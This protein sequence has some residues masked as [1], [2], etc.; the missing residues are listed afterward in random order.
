MSVAFE[1]SKTKGLGQNALRRVRE[2]FDGV[3]ASLP[4]LRIARGPLEIGEIDCA[5]RLFSVRW[6]TQE[7]RDL[8]WPA[9]ITGTT[10]THIDIVPHRTYTPIGFSVL[11]I[12]ICFGADTLAAAK[13]VSVNPDG[14]YTVQH[15]WVTTS[16]ATILMNPAILKPTYP[17]TDKNIVAVPWGH[18]SGDISGGTG[19]FAGATGT[20]NYFGMADFNKSTLVLRYSGTVCY[21]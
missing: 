6:G 8:P 14:T 17:T 4:D 20:I 7:L 13:I 21:K 9:A 5:A 18:Y 19:I 2:R 3:D 1:F 15:Y 16:G 11:F 10:C 12:G